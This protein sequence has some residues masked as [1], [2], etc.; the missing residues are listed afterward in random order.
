MAKASNHLVS[1]LTGLRE[2]LSCIPNSVL[3]WTSITNNEDLL[4]FQ[5]FIYDAHSTQS[6][7]LR[8]ANKIAMAIVKSAFEYV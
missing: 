5:I 6:N 2:I 8:R 3:I 7:I 1:S 4:S